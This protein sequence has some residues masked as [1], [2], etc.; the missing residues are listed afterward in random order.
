MY[1]CNCCAYYYLLSIFPLHFT[2]LHT[3]TY[4]RL[5]HALHDVHVQ[6]EVK[7]RFRYGDSHRTLPRKPPLVQSDTN[8]DVTWRDAQGAARKIGQKMLS[9]S[10]DGSNADEYSIATEA[11]EYKDRHSNPLFDIIPNVITTNTLQKYRT[12]ESL[13]RRY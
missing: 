5:F 1:H 11:E 8:D 2:S 9:T 3:L 4:H 10:P 13:P 6:V 12:G 7:L